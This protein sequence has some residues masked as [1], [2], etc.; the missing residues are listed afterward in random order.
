MLMP[1]MCLPN[2]HFTYIDPQINGLAILC[3]NF[4]FYLLGFN[5]YMKK[6]PKITI[7]NGAEKKP[8]LQLKINQY[9]IVSKVGT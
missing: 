8:P 7:A 1:A 2:D 3:H 6:N 4:H 9:N 5:I